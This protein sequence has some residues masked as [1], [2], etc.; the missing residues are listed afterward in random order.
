MP[1]EKI[2]GDWWPVG[3][4]ECR[5]AVM[6]T[7]HDADVAIEVCKK[8]NVVVQAG[9]NCGIWPRY[10]A[11]KFKAVYTFEPDAD[12]FQCLSRNA[13]ASNIIKLQAALGQAGQVPVDL[14]RT[15]GNVGAHRVKT[16]GVIPVIAIDQLNLQACDFMALDLEGYEYFALLGAANTIA[17][18]RPVLM[19]EDKGHERKYGVSR[20]A[21]SALLEEHNYKLYQ[22]VNRDIIMIPE[23]QCT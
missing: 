8:R 2:D 12:N 13:T 5:P 14:N 9:G 11:T 1:I 6:R 16:T 21:L 15:P 19:I 7:F 18:F 23:E 10:L 22:K 17:A 20:D 4:T 3:D